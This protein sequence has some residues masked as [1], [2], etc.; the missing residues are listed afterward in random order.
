[1]PGQRRFERTSVTGN[2]VLGAVLAAGSETALF[3]QGAWTDLLLQASR[4]ETCLFRCSWSAAL[5]L[6]RLE[7]LLVRLS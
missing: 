7:G 5:G 3:Q 2:L 6:E 1:M 4:V